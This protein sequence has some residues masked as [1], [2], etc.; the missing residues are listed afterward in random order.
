MLGW[1]RSARS[2]HRRKDTPADG[3]TTGAGA[4]L[5]KGAAAAA[6]GPDGGEARV[7]PA[8]PADMGGA[9]SVPVDALGAAPAGGVPGWAGGG[10]GT[11]GQDAPDGAVDVGAGACWAGIPLPGIPVW[12]TASA[13]TNAPPKSKAAMAR[14]T[15]RIGARP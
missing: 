7:D 4:A 10:V 9:G 13:G 2:R 6:P 15:G 3:A 1:L 11:D 5:G 14:P 8:A 12:A